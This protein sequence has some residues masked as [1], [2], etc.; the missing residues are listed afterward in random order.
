MQLQQNALLRLLRSRLEGGNNC[1]I[2]NIFEFILSQ[3]GAFNIFHSAQF[4]SHPVSVFLANGLHLLA[5]KL[6]ADSRIVTQIG[7]GAHDKAGDTRA[8]VMNFGEPFFA[9]VFKG[10][11]GCHGEADQE[12]VGLWVRKGTKTVIILLTS[13]IKKSQGVRFIADHDSDGIIIENGRNIF[14]G[15]FVCCV[16]N[17]ET[18]LAHSTVTDDNTLDSGD[19]HIVYLELPEALQSDCADNLPRV[20]RPEM[21]R[22]RKEEYAVKE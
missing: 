17:Q 7:L 15:E 8:V 11:G 5:G 14:G 4:F 2:K 6:F 19:N 22:K 12:D 1:L 10:S 3:G 13:S 16:G 18:C 9:H 21:M 20:S